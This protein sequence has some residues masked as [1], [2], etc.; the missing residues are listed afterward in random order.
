LTVQRK[1]QRHAGQRMVAVDD[2]FVV[3]DIGHG[4]DERLAGLAGL[5]FKAHADFD[6]GRKLRARLDLHELL[7]I[8]AEGVD[9]LQ[10]DVAGLAGGL[11]AQSLL[12]ARKNSV[13]AAVQILD[14]LLG[15][16]DQLSLGIQQLVIQRYHRVLRYLHFPKPFM[17]SSTCAAWPR[18][19]TPYSTCFNLP[20]LPM[21]KV[22]LWMQVFFLPSCSFS[23]NTP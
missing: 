12:D 9:R 4:I 7:V 23:C 11:A 21:M 22:D 16:L 19:L 14:R 2:H 6:L 5:A 15:F 1:A 3:G 8:F 20:S 18:G 10:I 13:V 17:S